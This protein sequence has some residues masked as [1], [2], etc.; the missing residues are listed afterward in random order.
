MSKKGDVGCRQ[1]GK[2]KVDKAIQKVTE[3]ALRL[4]LAGFDN[5]AFV[6]ALGLCGVAITPRQLRRWKARAYE[7][8]PEHAR[9]ICEILQAQSAA[10]LGL[11]RTHESARYWTW[12]TADERKEEMLR[13][14]MLA[15]TGKA[16]GATALLLP[17]SKLT[18]VAQLLD[19][20]TRIGEPELALAERTATHLAATYAATPGAGAVR[21]AQSHAYTLIDLLKRVGMSLDTR[22]RLQSIA[23]DAAALAGEG[24]LNAGRSSQAQ[25]WFTKARD[26]AVESG[27]RRLEA[28]A[29]AEFAR[30]SAGGP[31]PDHAAAV[32]A[33]EPA[34]ELQ[35][36]LPPRGRALVFAFLAEQHAELGD[37]LVS[38]RFLEH[39]RAAA[40]RVVLEGPGWGWWSSH[41]I[42]GGWDGVRPQVF[43]GGRLLALGRP[44][45]ALELFDAALDGT[46][47]PVRR[48]QMYE[49]LMRACVGV[50]DP[51]RACASAVAALGEAKTY[52]LGKC[53]PQIRAVRLS[54]PPQWNGQPP[55]LDLDERLALAA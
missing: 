20:T 16:A 10:E 15:L 30:I 22:A 40:A 23:S 38:G 36:F 14:Q 41:G 42:L 13:R 46:T 50:D 34:A 31:E 3:F 29:R 4:E 17:V 53:V 21:A 44:A 9:V 51:E 5:A 54:F 55:V 33:L 48:A 6:V 32:A 37:D 39:A 25:A 24:N 11:G 43:A 52:E 45:E 35:Q 27:D 1:R 47:V 8:Y 19:G 18:G 49:D 12:M 28:L 26:L 7:P 2:S